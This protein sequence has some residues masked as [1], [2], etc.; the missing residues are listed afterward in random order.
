MNFELLDLDFTFKE[1]KAPS[2]LS[3]FLESL[4]ES[5]G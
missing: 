1:E 4:S 3:A 2:E 5:D